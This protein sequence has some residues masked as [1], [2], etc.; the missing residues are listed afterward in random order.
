[1][2]PPRKL[3]E[4]EVYDLQ[5]DMTDAKSLIADKRDYALGAK[6]RLE[7]LLKELEQLHAKYGSSGP[8]SMTPEAAANLR[9]L[10][11]LK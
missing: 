9:A 3:P 7:S 10:G 2:L 11:Y 8:S 4:L 6:K 1:M 5:A